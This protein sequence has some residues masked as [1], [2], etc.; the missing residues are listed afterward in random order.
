MNYIF[1]TTISFL[2][3]VTISAIPALLCTIDASRQYA[4]DED[5]DVHVSD[6]RKWMWYWSEWPEV[7]DVYFN[8]FMGFLLSVIVSVFWPITLPTLTIFGLLKLKR[9]MVRYKKAIDN[10]RRD[11]DG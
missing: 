7:K 1:M 3:F 9:H 4:N 6:Y 10:S 2:I 11:A 8:F 5:I